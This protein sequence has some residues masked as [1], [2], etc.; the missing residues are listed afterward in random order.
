MRTRFQQLPACW[1]SA[2][3]L[4]AAA[5]SQSPVDAAVAFAQAARSSWIDPT[6]KA[7][8][9]DLTRD[10][11]ARTET[12]RPSGQSPIEMVVLTASSTASQP[13][14][15]A[16]EQ[17]IAGLAASL[18][19]LSI[20]RL[21]I[22]D[23]PIHAGLNG[24]AY[25]GIAVISVRWLTG[26]RDFTL[27][28][29]LSAAIA[30]QYVLRL[31]NDPSHQSWLAEGLA[32]YLATRAEEL[33]FEPRPSLTPRYF[34]GFIP[35]SIRALVPSMIEPR[36]RLSDLDALLQRA[37]APWRLAHGDDLAR[38]RRLAIALHTLERLIGWPALQAGL[39]AFMQR[40]DGGTPSVADLA[41][42]LSEQRGADLSWFFDE[43]LRIDAPI[44]YAVVDVT[45]LPAGSGQWHTT[46]D[47][48]RLADGSFARSL[49]VRVLFEDDNELTEWIDGRDREWRFEYT[50]ASRAVEASVDPDAM[51]LIDADRTNNTRTLSAPLHPLGLRLAFN[52]LAWLQDAMLTCTAV[53]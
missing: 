35:H 30:R 34:G 43:P 25:P 14:V 8:I 47:V 29:D 15:D 33:R 38:A 2:G 11:I 32:A 40:H 16:A 50:S 41:A 17:A 18:G 20:E 12:F 26:R 36:P 49:P 31:V 10:H 21:T 19:P 9:Q 52:W 4:L 48:R 27:D 23:L 3:V 1:L 5:A 13:I 39:S 24:A 28:R 22:V 46:V 44:D 45:S 7:R 6:T 37:D 51:L 42:V 53:L